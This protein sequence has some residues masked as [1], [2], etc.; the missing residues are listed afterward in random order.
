MPPSNA[1]PLPARP[2]LAVSGRG[3]V[4]SANAVSCL[5][6]PPPLA[7]VCLV[8][9]GL[10]A[11]AST[12]EVSRAR[13]LKTTSTRCVSARARCRVGGF[14]RLRT[15]CATCLCSCTAFS[16]TATSPTPVQAY[17][18]WV[19]LWGWGQ[20][21][22]TVV[23]RPALA[24]PGCVW[25]SGHGAEAPSHSPFWQREPRLSSPHVVRWSCCVLVER[26]HA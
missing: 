5:R 20:P 25:G 15:S 17:I 1:A 9:F 26:C 11:G 3:C 2:W 7:M 24:A 14:E 10:V 12:L 4:H 13:F 8:T 16:P 22:G 21:R 19:G 6:A 23:W 18:L